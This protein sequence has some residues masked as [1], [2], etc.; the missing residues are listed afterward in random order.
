[1]IIAGSNIRHITTITHDSKVLTFGTGADG[2]IYYSVKRSGF[3]DSALAAGADPMGFEPWRLLRLGESA[4][5]ASVIAADRDSYSDASG[6]LLLRSVYGNTPEV[7]T[8]IDAPVQAVSALGPR[9]RGR[10]DRR[11]SPPSPDRARG[12]SPVLL[13]S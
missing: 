4:P 7:T 8:T 2:K 1:M 6:A 5:D 9:A 3:E 13:A 12:G 11:R 10:R